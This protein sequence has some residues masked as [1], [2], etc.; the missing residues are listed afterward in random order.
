[1]QR[2]KQ[3]MKILA[4]QFI[5]TSILEGKNIFNVGE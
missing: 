3:P 4:G 1:M 5:Q 2:L